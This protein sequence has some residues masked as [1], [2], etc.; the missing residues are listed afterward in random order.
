MSWWDSIVDAASDLSGAASGI[1][2]DWTS[3]EPNASS[4]QKPNANDTGNNSKPVTVTQGAIPVW[5]MVGGGV[6]LVVILILVL[7]GGK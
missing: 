3:K 5:A 6:L 4:T 7:R 2:N 1:Y